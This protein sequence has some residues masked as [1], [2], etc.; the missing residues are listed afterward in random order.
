MQL[1]FL[2][3]FQMEWPDMMEADRTQENLKTS[4]SSL[5]IQ[6]R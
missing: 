4:F 3:M 2:L 6:K 1:Q 5:A